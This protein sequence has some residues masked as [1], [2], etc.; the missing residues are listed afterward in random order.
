MKLFSEKV[1]ATFTNSSFNVLQVENFSEIFFDV[2]EIELNKI[3]YPVE[4]ISSFRGNPVVSVP[5]VI[6]ENEQEYPFVL[7]KGSESIVFNEQNDEAPVDD[8]VVQE[9]SSEDVIFEN[10]DLERDNRIK[11]STRRELL[12]QIEV[13]K[14]NAK[15]QAESI[16]H[17]KIKEADIEIRKKNKILTESLN[18]AKQELVKE[19]LKITKSLKNELVDGA[20]DRYREISITVDNKITD[21]A[22]RLSESIT[23]DFEN[24]S[25][26]FESK[27]RD[28]VKSL[29]NESVV[30]ELRKSLETIATDAVDRIKT[31]E[32]NLEKQLSDKAE[33]SVIEELSQELDVLRNGNIELNNNINKGVNKALSRIGNVNNRI[34][35]VAEEIT[36]QVDER[37][38][39]V[40]DELTEYYSAKLQS[41]ED[42]TF[43]LN[44]KS[45][46]YVIELVQESRTN[47]I[48]EI[49]NIQKSAPVEFIIESGGKKKVKSFDVIDKDI[50]KK[51]S[52]KISDEIIKLKRYI[53]VYSGG[54]GSVAQQFAN[55]GVMNGNLTVFGAISAS[56]YLGIP[57]GGVSGDYLPLSGGTVTGALVVQDGFTSNGDE[58]LF[59][60]INFTVDTTNTVIG[61]TNTIDITAPT[62]TISGKVGIGTATPTA[63]L[64]IL[65]TTSAVGSGL[66]GSALNIAQTWNTNLTPTA[67]SVNVT[68][69]SSNAA[70]LL[71]DL[72]VGGVSQLKVTKAGNL[73]A[74]RFATTGFNGLEFD[75]INGT[76]KGSRS[77]DGGIVAD[78]NLLSNSFSVGTLIAINGSV[79]FSANGDVTLAR[80]A[81]NTLAQRNGLNAQE[82]RIYSTY[83][84]ASNYERF[85]IKT[86]V[87]ATS[88]TQIGLSAAGTGRNRNLEF[89]VDG[90]TKMTIS[91]GGTIIKQGL[92]GIN[93]GYVVSGTPQRVQ[94]STPTGIHC[95]VGQLGGLGCLFTDNGMILGAA[96]LPW[97][98]AYI[99]TANVTSLSATG[100]ITTGGGSLV[101]TSAD[102][103]FSQ[104]GG[105]SNRI[106]TSSERSIIRNLSSGGIDVR[107]NSDTAGT[108]AC[109]S[110]SASGTLAVTGA[111]TAN[112]GLAVTS[113]SYPVLDVTRSA[114]ATSD[115]RAATRFKRENSSGTTSAG[116]GVGCFF[117]I[118]NAANNLKNVG[119]F[120]GAIAT[121]TA[122]AEVGELVF[123]PAWLGVDPYLRRDMVLRATSAATADLSLAG[124]LSAS[125]TL[126]VTG[127]VTTAN[128]IAG[129]EMTAPAAPAAN[130]YRIYAED[131][132]AGKTRLMVLFATGAAQQI[133][134]QP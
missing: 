77:V 66:S 14:T 65:D 32:V 114:A 74:G 122:G 103:T 35:V 33:I 26:E 22:E 80:D 3:K 59:T 51:I 71:M 109:G 93:T 113:T 81:A 120:G 6:G 95:M 17:Q 87:G 128:F 110:L 10:I 68:D 125:G 72:R 7:I 40:S 116:M 43:D 99:T 92:L 73:T 84:D 16:K 45:R 58:A 50:N 82:S 4:K 62:I 101:V 108:V 9:S 2:Y 55:G 63:K 27:I 83:T 64:D 19:F 47:L 88:A 41:L 131:N 97:P 127:A 15:Q 46:Q 132:G 86:N 42:Q 111:I 18:T 121:A 57:G 1:E 13:A 76:L 21:L 12:Q 85:F 118:P 91:S 38:S 49:R 25:S 102:G 70:S 11:D 53:A 52:D 78:L 126:A 104:S 89:V 44:E 54:G 56:Q 67:L 94:I 36:K 48:S 124:N 96:S 37:V 24:S 31:I 28:F 23:S 117:E 107:N 98:T 8:M 20:D 123:A 34:D 29:H 61:S 130:G 30:P 105:A 106:I 79:K 133:A 60:G 115:F 129:A 134:I 112:S 100:N 75:S 69:L 119:F 90:S 39:S 5:V